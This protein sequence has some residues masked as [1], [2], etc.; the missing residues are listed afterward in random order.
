MYPPSVSSSSTA[1]CFCF[2]RPTVK[3]ARK[4]TVERPFPY[5]GTLP[6]YK[7]SETRWTYHWRTQGPYGRGNKQTNK[8]TNTHLLLPRIEGR[9]CI[10][11]TL[12]CK[13]NYSVLL[14]C[15]QSQI[16]IHSKRNK[17]K[18]T[19]C[20]A[21]YLTPAAHLVILYFWGY[22]IYIYLHL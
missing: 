11:R 22:E 18:F 2:Y 17:P 5:S 7:V 19:L 4:P 13:H 1:I 6:K 14:W 12:T 20:S 9:S 21:G 10:Q 3:K 15:H 8:Q 16:S